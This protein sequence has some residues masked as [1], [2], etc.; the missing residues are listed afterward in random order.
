MLSLRRGCPSSYRPR[1]WELGRGSVAAGEEL[2]YVLKA[3]LTL[4]KMVSSLL[5][6]SY[7]V[8]VAQSKLSYLFVGTTSAFMYCVVVKKQG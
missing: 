7:S 1:D 2:K 5:F 8:N 3:V 6:F 4:V